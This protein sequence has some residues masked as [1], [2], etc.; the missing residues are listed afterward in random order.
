MRLFLAVLALFFSTIPAAQADLKVLK[1]T[2][3]KA[4]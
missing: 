4:S 2:A 1:L 3:I